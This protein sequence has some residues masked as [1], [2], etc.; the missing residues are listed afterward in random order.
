[1]GAEE[2]AWPHMCYKSQP[3]IQLAEAAATQSPADAD[4]KGDAARLL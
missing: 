1:M 4:K 2:H 3:Q